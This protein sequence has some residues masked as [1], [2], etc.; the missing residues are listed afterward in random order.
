MSS[1]KFTKKSKTQSKIGKTAKKFFSKK[2]Q[3]QNSSTPTNKTSLP[4]FYSHNLELGNLAQK[5][6]LSKTFLI[7]LNDGI[8]KPNNHNN[9]NNIDPENEWQEIDDSDDDT[10]SFQSTL[11]SELFTKEEDQDFQVQELDFC[12]NYS[13]VDSE[14]EESRRSLYN[15]ESFLNV[16]GQQ[17]HSHLENNQKTVRN[18]FNMINNIMNTSDGNSTKSENNDDKDQTIKSLLKTINHLQEKSYY[19]EVENLSMKR[20]QNVYQKQ[21]HNLFGIV[22]L[23]QAKSGEKV[24]PTVRSSASVKGIKTGTAAIRST[25]KYRK[26]QQILSASGSKIY[27]VV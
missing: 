20:M 26:N 23:C 11:D 8:H 4:K 24:L 18:R 9:N 3:R 25:K 13:E 21:I 16:S 17:S 2:I 19:L 1:I 14:T 27:T 15:E 10:S 12:E 22:D 6:D 5:R 7:P